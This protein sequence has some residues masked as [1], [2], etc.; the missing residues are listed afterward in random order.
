[1]YTPSR[2]VGISPST[3]VRSSASHSVVCGRHGP[4]L[5]GWSSSSGRVDRNLPTI[6]GFTAAISDSA[7]DEA[8]GGGGAAAEV[9]CSERLCTLGLVATGRSADLLGGV[10]EH[11][12]AR[13]THRVATADQP[14]AWIDRQA[15]AESDLVVFDRFPRFT[16]PR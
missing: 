14:A 7:H 16:G 3:A 4:V 13:R 6:S 10:D 5:Y 12:H 8:H 11:A 15:S 9:E 1:M 2:S